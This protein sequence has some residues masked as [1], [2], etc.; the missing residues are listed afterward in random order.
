MVHASNGVN[1]FQ[2]HTALL[3]QAQDRGVLVAPHEKAKSTKLNLYMFY[4]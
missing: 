1:H 2:S 3:R 4:V